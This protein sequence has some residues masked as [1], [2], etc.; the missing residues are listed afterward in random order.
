VD[1]LR[2]DHVSF[3]TPDSPVKT[4]NIDEF[5]RR[6]VSFTNV[7]PEALPTIPIRTQL[8][9]GQ[10]TLTNRPWQPLNKTDKTLAEL[11][12]RYRYK[13]AL[14]ADTY[15]Y[16]K[17][18]YNFHREFRVWKWIRGQEYDPYRSAPLKRFRLEDHI[19]D[20]FP[21]GWENLVRACLQNLEPLETSDD[22]YC[23]QVVREACDWLEDNKGS[24]RLFLWVDSFDPHEPWSPPEEFN[25][26]TDP[27]YKGKR[28]I[29]PPGGMASD[30]FSDEEISH[31]RGL[32]DG[33]VAYVDHYIG[34]LLDF[35]EREGFFDN[36]I[37]LF[38]SD[39]GH[40]LAD[41]GK[42]LKG[43]DRLY[44]ELLKVPVF[45]HFPND[46]WGGTKLD[47]LGLFHDL[48]ATLI[49]ALGLEDNLE[50]IQGRSLMPVIRGELDAIREAIITGFHEGVDRCIR[51]QRW[52]YIVRPEGEKNE[53]YD[54]V[55][56]PKEQ[57]N[58][59]DTHPEE[60][61]RLASH[62]GAA[63]FSGTVSKGLQKRAVMELIK[64]YEIDGTV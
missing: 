24:S 31:I 15:H 48:T 38:L 59:I 16:F 61:K 45:F 35:L 54:L 60:A 46:E 51:D 9:T 33:E 62:F 39:H 64:R 5:A 36:S 14:V 26:Y 22:F 12:R 20:K 49:E 27:H 10:R 28:Y 2:Q 4:T 41:H 50:A 19:N 18:G 3:Y 55:E 32:Y 7:Y 11:L 42:F 1:S 57:T 6:S 56:D 34:K 53:L 37:I 40:P 8:M 23:A 47:A 21:P 44:N 25:H 30:Y 58:L 17:P 63:Y 29:L 43:P 13:S 52:S